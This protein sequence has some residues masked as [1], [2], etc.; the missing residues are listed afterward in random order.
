MQYAIIKIIKRVS[1]GSEYN[2][3]LLYMLK[4]VNYGIS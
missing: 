1:K 2:P 4:Y 3:H